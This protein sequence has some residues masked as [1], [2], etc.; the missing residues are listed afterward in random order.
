MILYKQS[1][2]ICSGSRSRISNSQ[3]WMCKWIKQSDIDPSSGDTFVKWVVIV[4]WEIYSQFWATNFIA[5]VFPVLKGGIIVIGVA[6]LSHVWRPA[7]FYR[8]K[9]VPFITNYPNDIKFLWYWQY[10]LNAFRNVI[11]VMIK[12]K[13]TW[14]K[15][16][17]M[18]KH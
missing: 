1:Y 8:E 17:L 3:F 16:S 4:E 18:L 2:T 11:M 15:T 7:A 5:C 10:Y 12:D 13:Y 6:V 14:W 9:F